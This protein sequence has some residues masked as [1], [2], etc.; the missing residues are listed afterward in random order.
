LLASEPDDRNGPAQRRAPPPSGE[1]HP[2]DD[3]QQQ[4][5]RYSCEGG[6]HDERGFDGRYESAEGDEPAMANR[7]TDAIL[8]ICCEGRAASAS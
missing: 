1:D 8:A 6:E 5:H 7:P 2:E 3:G 4:D